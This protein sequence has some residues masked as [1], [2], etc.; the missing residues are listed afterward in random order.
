MRF[1]DVTNT[2][3]VALFLVCYFYQFLYIPTA[4]LRKLPAA[5]Q[6]APGRIAVLIAARNEE[7]VLGNLLGSIRA[8][9]YPQNLLHTYVIADNCT[10]RTAE[11][12]RA[13]G[14]VCVERRDPSLVGKG[15]ALN[16][17]LRFIRDVEKEGYD[18]YVVIDADNLLDPDFIQNIWNTRCSGCDI[19]TCCRNSKNYADNWISA[20]Y[21]LWY[22]REAQYL[23]RPRMLLGSSCNVS[24]TGF[25]FSDRILQKY[26]GWNFFLLVEDIE[27]SIDN[28]LD[29]EKIAYCENAVL[30][31]E[32][33]T[34]FA[35]SVRQRM[36]W[37]RGY[38]QVIE[39]YGRRLFAGIF[40]GDFSCFDMTMNILPAAILTVTNLTINLGCAIA[41][42]VSGGDLQLLL[43]SLLRAA[44]G[45]YLTAFVLGMITTITERKQIHASAL[46]KILYMFTFPLFMF[47]YVPICIAA[48]FVNPGWKPI[49]HKCAKTIDQM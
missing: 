48:L 36:R 43:L 34:N 41:V 38:L 23:N 6:A 35:Q 12:A 21:S 16:T 5:P 33:P 4:L 26:G 45:I 39:K 29:G 40:R 44:G 37:S 42:F 31:D 1:A 2:V 9:H 11:I 3:T 19:V 30:Y 49:R 17:L 14:A 32:Q 15:Y 27:F 24:G 7:A 20:G 18:A 8:Q 13:G 46:Q 22:L 28:I 47:T 25:L 10:D